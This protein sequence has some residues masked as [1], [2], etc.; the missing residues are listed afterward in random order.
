M[1]CPRSRMRRILGQRIRT[2]TTRRVDT[3]KECI[4]RA[5]AATRPSSSGPDSAEACGGIS[6]KRAAM[7]AAGLAFVTVTGLSA[8]DQWPRFRGLQAGVIAD[9]PALPESWSDTENVVWK[10]T[11]PGL[12]WSS[13]I[14]WDDHIFLTSA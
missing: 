5:L 9:D 8:T 12:G 1:R 6:M 13:P 3:S 14:I 4:I 2:L 11:I 10:T 7:I